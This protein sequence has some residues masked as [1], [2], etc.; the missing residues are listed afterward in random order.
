M[1]IFFLSGGYP[2]EANVAIKK[3]RVMDTGHVQWYMRGA[4]VTKN[5]KN[6][7]LWLKSNKA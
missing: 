5:G 2:G 6:L 3:A 1:S 7:K 4:F